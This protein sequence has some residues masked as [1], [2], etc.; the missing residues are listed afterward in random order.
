MTAFKINENESKFPKFQK[1]FST[2][3]LLLHSLTIH[4]CISVYPNYRL[5]TKII[6]HNSNLSKKDCIVWQN[7]VLLYIA[8]GKLVFFC[9]QYVFKNKLK[10]VG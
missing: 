9:K 4:S 8:E 6:W 3:L 10:Y 5:N 1:I 7:S 2:K